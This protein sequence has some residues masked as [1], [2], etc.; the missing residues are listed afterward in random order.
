M[1]KIIYEA[2]ELIELDSLLTIHGDSSCTDGLSEIIGDAC[3][4]DADD[5]DP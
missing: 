1:E 4:S 5:E 3:P 2:P